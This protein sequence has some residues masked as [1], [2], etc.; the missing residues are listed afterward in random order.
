MASG[1]CVQTG[2]KRQR[3]MIITVDER[4]MDQL[5]QSNNVP[6]LK[7]IVLSSKGDNSNGSHKEV[8]VRLF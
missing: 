7:Q 1:T 8:S 2:P 4:A 6:L 3:I 5:E